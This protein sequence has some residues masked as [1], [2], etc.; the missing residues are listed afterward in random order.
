MKILVS[1]DLLIGVRKALMLE[2]TEF[3][4]KQGL[5]SLANALEQRL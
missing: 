4:L 1:D 5:I 2:I 3:K